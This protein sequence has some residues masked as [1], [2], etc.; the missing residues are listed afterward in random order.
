MG[1]LS[2]RLAAPTCAC[3][4][5]TDLVAQMPTPSTLWLGCAPVL[6]TSTFRMTEFP[7]SPT[8]PRKLSAVFDTLLLFVSVCACV[9]MSVGR[10]V[11]RS[12]GLSV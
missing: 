5:L 1:D 9:R 2:V 12:V 3:C 10:S 11:G 7:A 4:D 8:A 6:K